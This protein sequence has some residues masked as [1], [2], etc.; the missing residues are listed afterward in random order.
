MCAGSERAV[1][2]ITAR[3]RHSYIATRSRPSPIPRTLHPQQACAYPQS[4]PYKPVVLNMF[5]RIVSIPWCTDFV[6]RDC[7]KR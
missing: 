4:Y 5:I 6:V 7:H 1:A 2:L 3:S